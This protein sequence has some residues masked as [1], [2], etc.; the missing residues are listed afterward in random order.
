[1]SRSASAKAIAEPI[2][3]P[4][5]VV[6]LNN[7]VK[8][9]HY[10]LADIRPAELS[11]EPLR[12]IRFNAGLDPECHFVETLLMLMIASGKQAAEHRAQDTERQGDHCWI[13]QRPNGIGAEISRPDERKAY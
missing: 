2:A 1:M 4:D 5:S 12:L 7:Q 10:R 6:D 11:H 3:A 8:A 9:A 13:D